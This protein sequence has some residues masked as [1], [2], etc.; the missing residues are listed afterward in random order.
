MNV[1]VNS[2]TSAHETDIVFREP[3]GDHQ[4]KYWHQLLK[5]LKHSRMDEIA[6]T[7][8]II[9]KVI[10]INNVVKCPLLRF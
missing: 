5:Y 2:W 9:M 8:Y 6:M 1:Y 3:A 4:V 7:I 10:R